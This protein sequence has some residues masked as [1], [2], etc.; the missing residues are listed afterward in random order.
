[1][2]EPLLVATPEWWSPWAELAPT[3]AEQRAGC[4]GCERRQ[5]EACRMRVDQT[6]EHASANR[7]NPPRGERKNNMREQG[8]QQ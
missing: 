6:H 4:S 1:M 3:A 2:L 5:R 7:F 8:R